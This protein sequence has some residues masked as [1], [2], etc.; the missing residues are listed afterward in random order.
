MIESLET[1]TGEIELILRGGDKKV[2]W[3]RV[4]EDHRETIK[5]FQHERLVHL[6]VTLAVAMMFLVTTMFSLFYQSMI[7]WVVD[8]LLLVLLV[9]YIWHYF[10]LENGVQKLYGLDRKLQK[11]V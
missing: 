5:F 1:W 4:V 7:L 2:D 3:K 10:R 6:L 11:E 9:P 8:F